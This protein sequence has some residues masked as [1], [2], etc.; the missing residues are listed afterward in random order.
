MYTHI[1]IY[2]EI[3]T[4][5]MCNFLSHLPCDHRNWSFYFFINTQMLHGAGFFVYLQN[6][7]MFLASP[8]GV[9]IPAPMD[10]LGFRAGT[11]D[12]QGR[13]RV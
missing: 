8:V 3:N 9:S 12:G 4:V 11:A 6:W 2:T 13:P 1:Y 5:S 7:A 10:P